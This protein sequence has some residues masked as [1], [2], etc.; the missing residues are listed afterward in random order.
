MNHK[1]LFQL[2]GR[3]ETDC[4][5]PWRA[6]AGDLVARLVSNQLIDR[7]RSASSPSSTTHRNPGSGGRHVALR[8]QVARLDRLITERGGPTMI[9]SDN[10]SD[11][12]TSNAIL[13]WA[14]QARVEWHYIAPGNRYKI[15]SS[16]ASTPPADEL[17]NETLFTSLAQPPGPHPIVP[18]TTAPAPLQ[19]SDPNTNLNPAGPP[20]NP[21]PPPPPPT[22]QPG[23]II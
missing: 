8:H 1:K 6:Q 19:S 9:V 18:T 20:S 7:H 11:C 17:L 14:D 5:P 4:S 3:G 2:S 13:A 10:G 23:P 16:R 12:I 22:N 15:G 21:T